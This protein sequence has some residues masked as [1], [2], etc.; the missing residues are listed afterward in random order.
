MARGR[1]GENQSDLFYVAL[2]GLKEGEEARFE[3]KKQGDPKDKT[4]DIEKEISGLLIGAEHRIWDYKGTPTDSIVLYLK[5][6]H[7]G[8]KGETY[9]LEVGLSNLTRGLINSLLSATS[10]EGQPLILSAY[11]NKKG[12]ASLGVYL[13]YD[14]GMAPLRL[15]WKHQIEELNAMITIDIVK[16]KDAKGKVIDKEQKN[17]L[18]LNEYLINEFKDKVIPMV[19]EAKG[20]YV[21]PAVSDAPTDDTPDAGVDDLPF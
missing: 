20:S 10:F 1:S 12:F 15:D 17:Y 6:P 13:G 11:N 4:P 5:D 21:A 19:K 9:K 16:G 7:A 3:I 2:K 18:V 8:Q 14:S